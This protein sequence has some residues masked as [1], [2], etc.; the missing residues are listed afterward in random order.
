MFHSLGQIWSGP[1]SSVWFPGSD[2]YGGSRSDLRATWWGLGGCRPSCGLIERVCVSR[3]TRKPIDARG[4][5]RDPPSLDRNVGAPQPRSNCLSFWARGCLRLSLS[6]T[7]R[8]GARGSR[9]D[10][11]PQVE[12]PG[13]PLTPWAPCCPAP[14]GASSRRRRSR[15]RTSSPPTSCTASCTAAGGTCSA[16][17]RTCSRTCSRSSTR[18]CAPR[19]APRPPS[20]RRCWRS[21]SPEVSGSRLLQTLYLLCLHSQINFIKIGLFVEQNRIFWLKIAILHF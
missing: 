6:G 8:A 13:P 9:C 4:E 19:R 5:L 7:G 15:S 10:P 16:S 14:R 18:T 11:H 3:A 17:S 20:P 21:P 12:P 2:L 1:S